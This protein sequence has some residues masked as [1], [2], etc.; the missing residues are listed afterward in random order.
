MSQSKE[1]ITGGLPT[2]ERVAIIRA[3]FEARTSNA[4]GELSQPDSDMHYLLHLASKLPHPEPP[5]N[6][7]CNKCIE[8]AKLL[9]ECRDALPAI[10]LASARLHNIRLDLADRIE[11][12][13]KP[14]EIS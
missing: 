6:T 5:K 14:W 2:S 4:T 1:R 7:T 8:L 13:L 11:E 3:R 10:S 9:I 12:A